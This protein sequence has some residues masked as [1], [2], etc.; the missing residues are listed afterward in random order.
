METDLFEE[1]KEFFCSICGK[2][3]TDPLEIEEEICFDCL[4]ALLEDKKLV[5][6]L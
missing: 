1:E 2:K 5:K 4:S 6:P 3:I